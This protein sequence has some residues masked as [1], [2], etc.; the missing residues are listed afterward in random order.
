MDV[1]IIGIVNPF[2][3]FD[4]GDSKIKTTVDRMEFTLRTFTGGFV[5]YENDNYMGGYN[6]WPI[7]TLWM[8]WYYMQVNDTKKALECFWFVVNS[9]SNVGLLGEQV[10]NKT[11]KPSW[12]IGLT[13]SHAMF[14]ITLDMMLKNGLL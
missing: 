1:S 10:D 14:I 3:M 8:A 12:V 2:H 11:M 6:P 9:A 7:A 4:P 13:W 5:R